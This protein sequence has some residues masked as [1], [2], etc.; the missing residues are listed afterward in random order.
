MRKALIFFLAIAL[1]ALS[2]CSSTKEDKKVQGD[3]RNK[4]VIEYSKKFP[5]FKIKDDNVQNADPAILFAY[6]NYL[7]KEDKKD[8]AAFWLFIAQMRNTYLISITK[9]DATVPPISSDL[10][11]RFFQESG[12]VG[13]VMIMDTGT[14]AKS[15][16]PKYNKIN[17]TYDSASRQNVRMA[18][19][20]L[21]ELM[22]PYVL[23]N[24]DKQVTRLDD[25]IAYEKAHP[26][27]P[28]SLVD[29]KYLVSPEEQ[30][31]SK[32]EALQNIRDFQKWVQDNKEKI[33]AQRTKN[34]LT[35]E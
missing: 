17:A 21:G 12:F 20:G 31:K 28:E 34:G 9:K 3:P 30:A 24:L 32:E 26:I 35:N 6:S 22:R 27:Q 7:Y 18:A 29:A 19:S 14:T 15:T 10:F 23:Q 33:R 2:G 1:L 11:I 16:D 4:G 13:N 5:E 8:E 25:V